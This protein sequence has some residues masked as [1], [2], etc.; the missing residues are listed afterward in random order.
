MSLFPCCISLCPSFH[1][2]S[3]DRGSCKEGD[4]PW[5]QLLVLNSKRGWAKP[6]QVCCWRVLKRVCCNKGVPAPPYS[7]IM[8]CTLHSIAQPKTQASSKGRDPPYTLPPLTHQNVVPLTEGMRSTTARSII[9][10]T[11]VIWLSRLHSKIIVL[12]CNSN[13][14]VDIPPLQLYRKCFC[15]LD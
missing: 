1:S 6:L 11:D 10:Y 8:G 2:H 14:D 12:G 9:C 4:G 5:F 15:N 3:W 7:F 13:L